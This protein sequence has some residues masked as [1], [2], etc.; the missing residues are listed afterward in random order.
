[1]ESRFSAVLKLRKSEV[2]KVNARLERLNMELTGAREEVAELERKM[3]AQETPPSGNFALLRQFKLIIDAYK[4]ELRLHRGRVEMLEHRQADLQ[5]EYK[6]RQI[7]YEKIHYLH[8]QEIKAK[9][10]A[11]KVREAKELDEIAVMR[12]AGRREE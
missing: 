1:M 10:E 2:D 4:N 7:E 11:I 3:E 5:R 6:E 12:H 9:L 8:T